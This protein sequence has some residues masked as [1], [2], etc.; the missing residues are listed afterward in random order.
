MT[1][2]PSPHSRTRRVDA[3]GMHFDS[4]E[5]TVPGVNVAHI[6]P[7]DRDPHTTIYVHDV[8]S[9]VVDQFGYRFTTPRGNVRVH[10]IGTPLPAPTIDTRDAYMSGDLG[11]R[12]TSDDPTNHQGDTCPI[13][14][15]STS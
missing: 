1:T 8:T 7:D 4:H 3:D 15:T 10:L 11:G 6:I 9:L 12:C 2:S 14:E 5:L 13:H